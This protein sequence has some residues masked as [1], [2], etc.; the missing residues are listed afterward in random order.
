MLVI[1]PSTLGHFCVV[2][3]LVFSLCSGFQGVLDNAK[4]KKYLM[5]F[6][7]M[8]ADN[9]LPLHAK[10]ATTASD[11]EEDKQGKLSVE[12]G[13]AKRA[14]VVTTCSVLKLIVQTLTRSKERATD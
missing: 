1:I 2:I 8:V 9:L 3:L 6:Y 14:N 5:Q 11:K 12:Q 4:R 13:H 10:E 7:N